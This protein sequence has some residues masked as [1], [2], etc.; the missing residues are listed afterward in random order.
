[1]SL[2]KTQFVVDSEAKLEEKDVYNEDN[3]KLSGCIRRP[4][5]RSTAENSDTESEIRDFHLRGSIL[6]YKLNNTLSNG[7]KQNVTRKFKI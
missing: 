2:L 1:M 5:A 3:D 7:K 6:C 4:N